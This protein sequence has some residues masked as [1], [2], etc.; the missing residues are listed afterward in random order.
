MAG[1]EGGPEGGE[2]RPSGD[3]P[4][5]P[6]PPVPVPPLPAGGE[7][8]AGDGPG[9]PTTPK[10]FFRYGIA[11]ERKASWFTKF[12]HQEVE[13]WRPVRR[14]AHSVLAL[15]LGGLLLVAVGIV[16]LKANDGLD[17]LPWNYGV[18]GPGNVRE[19]GRMLYDALKAGDGSGWRTSKSFTL[20]RDFQPPIY[21][22]YTI[23]Q[24]YQNYRRYVASYSNPQMYGKNVSTSALQ[25]V[26]DPKT[27]ARGQRDP[28]L[29]D[30][31]VALPCGLQAW[32]FFNDTFAISIDGDDTFNRPVRLDQADIAWQSDAE[33]YGNVSAVNYNTFPNYRGGNTSAVP[34]QANTLFQNWMRPSIKPD[35]TKLY[36]VIH[37]PL[38]AGT[39]I[40]ITARNRYNSYGAAGSK[41]VF[42]TT[43][44]WLGAHN[45]FLGRF[46][47]VAGCASLLA[48]LVLF[49]AV[50]FRPRQMGD[51]S[52]LSWN[53]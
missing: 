52:L 38:L 29:P 47:I 17:P 46:Y 44:S 13:C 30:D 12:A 9:T 50:M 49:F 23:E 18:Y 14:P 33:L 27:F 2:G 7:G 42:L 6:P 32:A 37:E 8:E 26:C 43:Q 39:N 11:R 19:P 4:P 28:A 16:T 10:G 53:K 31:G 34:L 3:P 22:Y 24:F 35:V 5:P 51:A 41:K 25:M 45:L 1:A 15:L 48:G 40:T 20:D 36:A 21:M